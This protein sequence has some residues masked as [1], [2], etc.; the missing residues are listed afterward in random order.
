MAK[1]KINITQIIGIVCLVVMLGLI[2]TQFLPYWT[3]GEGEDSTELSVLDYT[4]FNYEKEYKSFIK[5]MKEQIKDAGLMDVKDDSFKK[6]GI[7]D[8]VYPAAVLSI[9][10]LF[11]VVFCPF[12][13]GKPLGI[14]FNLAVGCIGIWMY[15]SHPIYKLGS[16]WMV[17]LIISLVLAVLSLANAVLY[18]IK[19]ANS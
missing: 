13:L 16:L 15:L 7:N 9:V 4:W 8:F 12:K 2:V 6:L 19:K 1:T 5:D 18:I 10:A 17:G 14:A 3:I 11:A